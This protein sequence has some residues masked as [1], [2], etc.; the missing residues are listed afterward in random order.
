MLLIFVFPFAFSNVFIRTIII[1]NISR[2]VEEDQ[3]GLTGGLTTNVQSI[4]QITAPL[5]GYAY[6][7]IGF[8]VFLGLTID[9]YFLIGITSAL[10]MLLL[11]FII[12]Y[13]SKR[14]P[15][16]YLEA[17]KDEN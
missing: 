13:D 12:L 3:Q 15:E 16:I 10:T 9:A 1:S 14:Y 5:V 11:I 17:E 8:I 2:S 7:D 6:L 4:G